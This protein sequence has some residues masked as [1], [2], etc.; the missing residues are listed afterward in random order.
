MHARQ[1]V[2]L[3]AHLASHGEVLIRGAR[4]LSNNS[5][6]AY[7]TASK[8]RLD[9]WASAMK[10]MRQHDVWGWS[11]EHARQPAL[12]RA[13]LEEVLTGE[14]LTRV[15][16]GVVCGFERREKSN[17][18]EPVVRSVLVGH[19]EARHRALQLLVSGQCLRAEDVVSL[20]RLRRRTECWTDLLLGYLMPV[21]DAREFA[22]DPVRA[23]DFAQGL[24]DERQQAWGRHAWPLSKLTDRTEGINFFT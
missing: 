17:E 18:A 4:R 9:R 12:A 15:W 19:L 20:N 2:E 16:T 14:L 7:W 6:Q 8:C 3:A 23:R 1:L 22:F 11:H 5:L 21:H 13:L 24:Q 10:T